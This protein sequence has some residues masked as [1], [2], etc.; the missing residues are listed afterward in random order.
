MKCIA[1]QQEKTVNNEMSSIIRTTAENV[2][3][4]AE[5]APEETPAN[6]TTILCV[7]SWENASHPTGRLAL[8][9]TQKCKP[10]GKSWGAHKSAWNLV[11]RD[12][13]GAGMRGIPHQSGNL[14]CERSP[15]PP[16]DRPNPRAWLKGDRLL[17]PLLL[18]LIREL[19]TISLTACD[20]VCVTGLD[21]RV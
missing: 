10:N 6:I 9:R 17:L 12:Q 21:K 18:E 5:Y 7:S 13:N 11:I 8:S 16:E 20:T 14:M 3:K 19:T 2:N 4:K 1:A 15:L